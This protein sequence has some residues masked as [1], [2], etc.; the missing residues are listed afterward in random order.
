MNPF[1][2]ILG[3]L[4][5]IYALLMFMITMLL[6]I[7][8]VWI[9]DTIYKNNEK[10]RINSV[11]PVFVVWMQIFM[12]LVFCP[13][14]RKGKH[15]FEKGKNYVVVINHNSFVDIP[16]SSPW[17][18]GPNKTLAKIDMMKIPIF[19]I[20]YR[21][22]SILVD[23]SSPESRA[24]SYVKMAETLK[25]GI[26]LTLYPEGTR[27]K[28][29]QPLQPFH[30]GAFKTAIA[31]QKDI[32]PGIL[33]NTR[34]ILP[35]KP[36]FW[37]WPHVIRFEFLPPISVHGYDKREVHILKEKVHKIMEDYIVENR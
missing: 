31:N 15:H 19:N 3:H 28:T 35:G 6:V 37:A 20:I 30:D 1:K 22:G 14:K 27:N 13:V 36:K 33:F 23:R 2:R 24:M 9:I 26:H 21:S 32:I 5:F 29:N 7:P 11:F 25:D 10:K 16:V 12:N 8:P 17:V 4:F 34:N 18:P